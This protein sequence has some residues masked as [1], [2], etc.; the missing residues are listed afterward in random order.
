MVASAFAY[1]LEVKMCRIGVR[2]EGELREWN[3]RAAVVR[4]G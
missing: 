1:T 4:R 3:R 2:R